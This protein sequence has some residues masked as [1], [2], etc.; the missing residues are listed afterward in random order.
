MVTSENEAEPSIFHNGFTSD[1]YDQPILHKSS[2]KLIF[3]FWMKCVSNG[4][5]SQLTEKLT[6]CF[7]YELSS[8]QPQ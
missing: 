4:N 8:L 6:Q 2:Q 5:N 3:E 7:Y 1:G